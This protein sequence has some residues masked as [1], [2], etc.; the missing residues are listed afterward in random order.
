VTGLVGSNPT[1]SA[2]LG[3]RHLT[4]IPLGLGAVDR[5]WDVQSYAALSRRMSRVVGYLRDGADRVYPA[6]PVRVMSISWMRSVRGDA[7]VSAGDAIE[8]FAGHDVVR[9]H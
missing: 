7:V 1:L 6:T 8:I 2:K 9:G 5:F 4:G 3:K